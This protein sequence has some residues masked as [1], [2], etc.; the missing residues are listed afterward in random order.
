MPPIDRFHKPNRINDQARKTIDSTY[1]YFDLIDRS[2][3][4]ELL[5]TLANLQGA[6]G[7]VLLFQAGLR[8]VDAIQDGK[9]ERDAEAVIIPP[10]FDIEASDPCAVP[11]EHQ[12]GWE[13]A[14]KA[15]VRIGAKS[16][17][18]FQKTSTRFSAL[19]EALARARRVVLVG[20][21]KHHARDM[22]NF[23]ARLSDRSH[24]QIAS[25]SHKTLK[26]A[27]TTLDDSGLLK[28]CHAKGSSVVAE[29][30]SKRAS[31]IKDLDAIYTFFKV[32]I[33]D[34]KP[35]EKWDPKMMEY[36][37]VLERLFDDAASDHTPPRLLY[38]QELDEQMHR[39]CK[40]H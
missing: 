28:L 31:A 40:N 8:K 9:H 21:D 39:S 7:K 6:T 4:L 30:N 3:L 19:V 24:E 26:D 2:T 33:V 29:F 13:L 22:D 10:N 34:E 36:I 16:S 5:G 23:C 18:R 14:G 1:P 17:S 27:T 37:S 35:F 38:S 20:F 32:V 12:N 25:A 11:P 15:E